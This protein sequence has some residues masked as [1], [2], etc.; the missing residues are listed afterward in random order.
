MYIQIESS[1]TILKI[2]RFYYGAD[3]AYY[4]QLTSNPQ[5]TVM[6]DGIMTMVD[7]DVEGMDIDREP[8]CS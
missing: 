7:A 3:G 1:Q 6:L 8:L 5:P 4:V 2:D